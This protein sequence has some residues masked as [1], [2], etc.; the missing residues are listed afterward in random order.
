MAGVMA[1]VGWNALN[2]SSMAHRELWFV[3]AI[4]QERQE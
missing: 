3:A 4:N 2:S 1:M